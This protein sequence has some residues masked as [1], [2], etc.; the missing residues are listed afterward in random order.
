MEEF[1]YKWVLD[2]V[3]PQLHWDQFGALQG[4]S[5]VDALVYFMHQLYSTTDKAGAHLRAV[6]VDYQK[7]FDHLDHKI[8]I[9]KLQHLQVPDIIVEWIASFLSGRMQR[10]KLGNYMSEFVHIKGGVPQGTKLGPLLFLCMIDDLQVEAPCES[11]KF[12][13][14]TTLLESLPAKDSVSHLQAT[15]DSLMAWTNKNNMNLNPSKTKELRINFSKQPLDPTNLL[16]KQEPVVCVKTAKL[17]G[18]TISADLKWNCHINNIVKKASQRIY[19]LTVLKRF[20]ASSEHLLHVYKTVIRPIVEY[21]C[22]CWHPGLTKELSHEIESIQKRALRIIVPECESYEVALSKCELLSLENRRL[23]LCTNYFRKMQ[24][25]D[26]KLF[27]LLPDIRECK[28]S[29]RNCAKY[30]LPKV[31]TSRGKHRFVTWSL[32]N[33]Q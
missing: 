32:F 20:G 25:S 31:R 13:D 33:L 17:L 4:S 30:A 11:L 19:Y 5:T 2:I 12:V 28:Y 29:L 21:A 9:T 7:A 18:V 26:H 6:L 16:V 24:N 14:D 3:R 1:I 23:E 22:Q 15:L 10:V 27:K 8:I